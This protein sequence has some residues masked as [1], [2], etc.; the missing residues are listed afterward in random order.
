[1]FLMNPIQFYLFFL[2]QGEDFIIIKSKYIL[3]P[4][5]KRTKSIPSG[6]GH[7]HERASISFLIKHMELLV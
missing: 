6:P 3:Q 2:D 4:G 7:C 1:M 5:S